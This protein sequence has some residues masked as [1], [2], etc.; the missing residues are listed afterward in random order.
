MDPFKVFQMGAAF[1]H[2]MLA[3]HTGSRPR[4]FSASFAVSNKCNIHCSYC[5]FPGIEHTDLTLQQIEVIFYRLKKV[6]VKRLGILG[7]EPLFRKDIISIL[8]LAQKMQFSIS[9]NTNLLL[10][11]RYK[12][13]LGMVDY[14]FTSLDGDPETHARNRGNHPY[15]KVLEAIYAILAQKKKLTAICVVTMDTKIQT[16][17]YL[18]SLA[19]KKGFNLHFQP[20]CYD[21]EYSRRSANPGYANEQ[22]RQLWLYLVE[23]KKE[24]APVFSSLPYLQYISRWSDYAISV[25][26]DPE[27]SCAAGNTFFFVDAEGNAYPCAYTKGKAAPVSMLADN[28]KDFFDQSPPCT[29]CIVGPMLEFNLLSKHPVA[30]ALHALKNV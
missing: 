15:E 16:I 2:S 5:N 20:E 19:N 8:E 4:P 9:M 22:V 3:Y 28:W 30:S 26:N 29:K 17:D 10:Y 21:A 23:R 6:G 27:E 12:E 7:G 1:A 25:V 11:E 14:F 13:Q 24:G 18:L